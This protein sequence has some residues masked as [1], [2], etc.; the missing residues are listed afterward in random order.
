MHHLFSLFTKYAS[1]PGVI[2]AAS[3]AFFVTLA[4]ANLGQFET[5]DEHF[6]KF[7][8]IQKYYNGIE[9][10]V[11][12]GVWKKTRINDKPGVSVAWLAGSG[13][14]FA[15]V[16]PEAL[17]DEP[18]EEVLRAR[19]GDTAV[20]A[21]HAE[22]TAQTNF[23]LRLPVV[24]FS[25]VML[26]VLFWLVRALTGRAWLGALSV[27]A[28]A[29]SPAL[30]GMS[31]VL[32][33]D[34]VLWS[35]MSAAMIAFWVFVRDGG[36]RFL[37]ASLLCT[38][39]ALLSKYTASLLFVLLPMMLMLHALYVTGPQESLRVY[40][41]WLRTR[42]TGM[43]LVLF[44]GCVLFALGMP[45]VLQKPEHFFYGTLLSP[46]LASIA[47]P[48]LI[49]YGLLAVETYLVRG[50]CSHWLMQM[51]IAQIVRSS[52]RIVPAAF[53]ALLIIVS[54]INAHMTTPWLPLTDI[55]EVGRDG[56]ELVFPQIVFDDG[57][58]HTFFVVV[59]QMQNLIF[60]L[61]S[62]LL[63][64][65]FAALVFSVWRAPRAFVPELVFVPLLVFVFVGGGIVADVFVNVRYGIVLYPFVTL[66]SV[67]VV[68]Q[69]CTD[70]WR[71]HRRHARFVVGAVA[72]ALIVEALSARPF[73]LTHENIFLPQ[74][75]F[76]TDAWGYGFYE[77]AQYLNAQDNAQDLVVWSDGG[78]DLL[79]QFFVGSCLRPQKIDATAVVPD[80][81]I[82]SR[83][84]SAIRPFQLTNEEGILPSASELIARE[85]QWQ[86]EMNNRSDNYIKIIKIS[87]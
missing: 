34:A 48:L 74:K 26:G 20:S 66:F 2:T 52:V 73:F 27:S 65:F 40:G 76:V 75:S 5:T 17:R 3:I 79:C 78:G 61:P 54:V 44:G 4:S 18:R 43:L 1:W 60:A 35:T 15:H 80:Y 21:F 59:A 46:A 32:N 82:L 57:V 67:V 85:P 25:A 49:M 62:A 10:G 42:F 86:L 31:Q 19:Y 41:A 6:W 51:R 14:P 81:L 37:I 8:R 69:A 30:I 47:M 53:M 38:G 33:P 70:A 83:R 45:A 22:A 84:R 11:T 9:Q 72:I 24:L 12:E 39:F 50:K 64:L 28:S 16:H 58:L 7:D 63:V 68:Y 87:E 29:L 77:A 56:G 36:W 23:A 71:L 55:K 13:L